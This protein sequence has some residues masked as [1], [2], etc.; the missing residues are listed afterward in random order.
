MLQDPFVQMIIASLVWW[1][2]WCLCLHSS[3]ELKAV[4]VE[5]MLHDPALLDRFE[6][7]LTEIIS[8]LE[9]KQEDCLQVEQHIRT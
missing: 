7:F 3:T 8:T 6:S 4:W 2:R 9:Q 1:M 5:L